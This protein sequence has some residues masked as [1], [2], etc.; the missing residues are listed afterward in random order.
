PPRPTPF[1]YTTLFRSS[2][3][4]PAGSPPA[5]RQPHQAN[6][7][8]NRLPPPSTNPDSASI[9]AATLGSVAT[10]RCPARSRNPA[11]ACSTCAGNS[12]SETGESMAPSS[13]NRTI[14]RRPGTAD[15]V[16]PTSGAGPFGVH[17]PALRGPD[18]QP[19]QPFRRRPQREPADVVDLGARARAV[20]L[21]ELDRA[22]LGR[23]ELAEQAV[24]G[25]LDLDGQVPGVETQ[26]PVPAAGA[27]TCGCGRRVT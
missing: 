20:R 23:D 15:V 5:P 21:G 16:E 8:R 1:P 17:D 7:G 22:G 2:A 25:Q 10:I 9:P 19:E 24:R 3:S 13:P 6:V 4:G 11:S 26:C 27:G 18:P 12:V 14:T